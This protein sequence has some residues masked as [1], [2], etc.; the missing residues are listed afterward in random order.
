MGSRHLNIVRKKLA[1]Y[2]DRGVFR[3]FR[4]VGTKGAKTVFTFHW[5]ENR[6][7]IFIYDDRAKSLELKSCL[8]NVDPD[9]TKDV[10]R[11]VK[12]RHD[13]RLPAHRR[14]DRNRAEAR[15]MRRGDNITLSL[16]IRR[17]QLSYG[18]SR[19]LN[20]L[21]EVFVQLHQNH[22]EYMIREFDVSQD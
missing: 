20:L 19:L 17:N 15:V 3:D 12:T 2:A 4:E 9:L 21:N 18:V 14:V 7:L 13:K 1:E 22:F 8:P 5:L 10:R 16:Q 6:P 11:Y